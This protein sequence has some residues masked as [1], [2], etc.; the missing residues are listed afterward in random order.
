M[1]RIN[2]SRTVIGAGALLIYLVL[3]VV[4]VLGPTIR[5]ARANR[6]FKAG[7]Y[8]RARDE[9]RSLAAGRSASPALLHNLG[10]SWYQLG[11]FSEARSCLDRASTGY[12]AQTRSGGR[13]DPTAALIHYHLGNSLF[14]IAARFGNKEATSQVNGV[15]QNKRMEQMVKGYAAA[16]EEY[17]KALLANPGDF[18]AKYNY[19]VTMMRLGQSPPPETQQERPP[20]ESEDQYL[21]QTY[22]DV[23][24]PNGK[25]W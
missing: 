3:L 11:R 22:Q 9:Y 21:N 2:A 8:P 24:P 1:K 25:D 23:P 20:V 15:N 16:L 17:K 10:I 7:D 4:L 19:E 13:P 6:M 5:T 14:Q 18:E 12:P